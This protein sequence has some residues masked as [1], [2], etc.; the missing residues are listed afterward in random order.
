[1]HSLLDPPQLLFFFNIQKNSC[2]SYS[3]LSALLA[4]F[5][6]YVEPPQGR[7]GE[8][9]RG[10]KMHT[11]KAIVLYRNQLYAVDDFFNDSSH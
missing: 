5:R 9:G 8:P 6:N 10:G 7:A 1:M 4:S 2:V 11:S 3:Q